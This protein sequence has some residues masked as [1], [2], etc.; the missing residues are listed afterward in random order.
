M[1]GLKNTL[2][3]LSIDSLSSDGSGVGRLDGKAV[4]VPGTAPGDEITVRIV[5][6]LD[7]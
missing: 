7:R 1:P 3:P 5:K 4:F 6:D 2:A